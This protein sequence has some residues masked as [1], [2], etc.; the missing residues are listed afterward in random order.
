M[1]TARD[2][3]WRRR[4]VRILTSKANEVGESQFDLQAIEDLVDERL[5][6]GSILP[7]HEGVVRGAALVSSDD[8]FVVPTLKGR[9]FVEEQRTILKSRTFL[10][11]IKANWPLFSGI[12]GIIVGWSL[13]L[14][15]PLVQQRFHSSQQSVI[16]STPSPTPS[17]AATP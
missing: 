10:G 1:K 13:G 6:R 8:G 9:L 4:Y 11:R 12:I 3:E 2:D 16:A 7:D 17:A 5:I 14:L 15:S